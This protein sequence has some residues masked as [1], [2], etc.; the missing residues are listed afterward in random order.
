MER[1]DVGSYSKIKSVKVTTIDPKFG[2]ETSAVLAQLPAKL[3]GDI[4]GATELSVSLPAIDGVTWTSLTPDAATVSGNT[5]SIIPSKTATKEAI[6]K[7]TFTTDEN[8]RGHTL[9]PCTSKPGDAHRADC[10][11]DQP[12]PP[13]CPQGWA[14]RHLQSGVCGRLSLSRYFRQGRGADNVDDIKE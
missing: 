11:D 8:R 6:V 7:A 14:A 4:N 3:V 12:P 10:R 1:L 13:A 5:L 9:L 2:T